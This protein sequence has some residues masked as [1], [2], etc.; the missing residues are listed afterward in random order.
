MLHAAP[1]LVVTLS[2]AA[3]GAALGYGFQAA[4]LCTTT[5]E[6]LVSELPMVPVAT[7]AGVLTPNGVFSSMARVLL[8][9]AMYGT[10]REG[11]GMHSGVAVA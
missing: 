11:G 6:S 3:F 8:P 1:R 2:K 10:L 5:G 7:L 4:A 9:R